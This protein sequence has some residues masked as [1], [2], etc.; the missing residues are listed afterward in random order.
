M[1]W[2]HEFVLQNPLIDLERVIREERGEASEELK[3]KYAEGPPIGCGAVAGR[4]DLQEGN[5][6]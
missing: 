6:G 4:S 2:E 1:G 3:E 5:E